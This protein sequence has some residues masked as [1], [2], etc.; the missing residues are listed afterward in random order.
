MNKVEFI[1]W[2]IKESYEMMMRFLA[3]EKEEELEMKRWVLN[4]K[5]KS[6]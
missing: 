1:E 2:Y 5:S 3:K 4:T 6:K